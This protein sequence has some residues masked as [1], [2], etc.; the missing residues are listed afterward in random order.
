MK[1]S[2]LRLVGFKTFVDPTEIP[3]EPGLSGIVGPNG[4]GKSNLV[5]ALRWVM[6]E[7][8]YKSLRA[9]EMDDVIF[10]GSGRRP[11]RNT[12]EVSLRIDNR[13]RRA[14]VSFNDDEEL[15][16]TRRIEREAGSAYRINGRDVRARD[17]QLLFADAATGAHSA[18][19]VRQGQI[20]ELIAA[21][22]QA[23]R[24]VLEDA[25]GIGGLYS[26][27]HEAELR[28]KAAE[29]NLERLDDLITEVGQT[30]DQLRRQAKQARRYRDLSEEIRRLEAL[31][32]QLRWTRANAEI[33]AAT[34]ALDANRHSV[35]TATEAA[36]K[37]A[38][39]RTEAQ[40][41]LPA[42][43]EAEAAAGARLRRLV[44]ERDKLSDK[45][46]G[47]GARRAEIERRLE[48]IA[49]DREREDAQVATTSET[50]ER[51]DADIAVLRQQMADAEQS[52]EELVAA[53][54]AAEAELRD[55]EGG[56]ADAT[57]QAAEL[58]ARRN[59]LE[60][61]V[62]E[63]ATRLTKLQAQRAEV[64]Q[65]VARI[66]A[67]FAGSEETERLTASREAAQARVD[68]C[69]QAIREAETARQD[70]SAAEAEARAP[71]RDAENALNSLE[72]EQ[73]TLV[74]LLEAGG[75]D[76]FP[77]VVGDV[78]VANGFETAL[79]AA[80][81]DDLER[82][83]DERAGVHWRLMSGG[84]DPALPDGVRPLSA[85]VEAPEV[86][87][88]RLAQI[89][90][91]PR[92]EGARL[93]S[94]LQAGQI[95]VS[96]EG[97]V[98]RWDG[99]VSS[100]EAPTPAATRLAQ[101]NRVAELD[102]EIE[103]ARVQLGTASATLET[104]ASR[105]MA[106]QTREAETRAALREAQ[107]ELSTAQDA[108]TAAERQSGQYTAR[109]SALEEAR[110]RLGQ[111]AEESAA[112]EADA[113]Q[114]LDGLGSHDAMVKSVEDLRQTVARKR[115]AF[116]E[117]RATADGQ[118]REREM[119]AR[120]LD[121]M[122]AEVERWRARA[123][124]TKEHLGTLAKREAELTEE[125]KVL[126][127]EPAR[128]TAERDKVA[129]RISEAETDRAKA[130]DAHAVGETRQAEADRAARAADQL[131]AER[132]EHL[133]R[134]EATLE[135]LTAR[136]GEIAHA[137]ED[138]L[139]CAPDALSEI[140]GQDEID[141]MVSAEATES[142]LDRLKVDRDRMGA[143]NLRAET[144]AA[145]AEA[146]FEELTKDR[147]DLDQA[148]RKLRHGIS[149]LNSEGR[150]RL[151]SA[152][153]EVNEHFKTL[154]STLFGG[155]TAELKLT[156]SDDPLEAGLEIIARP[157]GKRPQTLTLLSGGEQALT[158]IAL[159]FAVF[160]TNPS[161]ICVL[162]EVDAPLDDANVERFC[163][164]MDEMA[165]ITDTR[166]LIITHNPITMSRVDRLFGVT[167]AEKGVSQMVSVDLVAANGLR[168]AE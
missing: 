34:E 21:K 145:E 156:E 27:R 110:I 78:R 56:L 144:E 114:A 160:L 77:P 137:I 113:A 157:P 24:K 39:E 153:T 80:L 122:S 148:I 105:S 135:G 81:G 166:Y 128:L 6:G 79:G 159:I 16:V 60:R 70:A 4:C 100:A 149:S 49:R 117:K 152:F 94:A 146:R 139:G 64:D 84:N 61:Q 10:A 124:E 119:H 73:R 7:N 50:V 23:R 142:R 53:A 74:G 126:T 67:E 57:R 62:K 134:A 121:Q 69:E 118:Q 136:R 101:R 5:E 95:L 86:L 163:N 123:A 143:V 8:S 66:T 35:E 72:A 93:Q 147:D 115:A 98:W 99:I 91:V 14:P 92:S 19:M 127:R 22:P 158:A 165:R 83:T 31:I 59:Q 90:I 41:A 125:R 112:A 42:L 46:E 140:S 107:K 18:A 111:S 17:V 44:Q 30:R 9:S 48:E 138:H 13:S 129:E 11:A 89:G 167:M 133:A 55:A 36:A 108:L 85:V 54:S 25:A 47:V 20:G 68:A 43:R 161:P 15:E 131:L 2:R 150:Q 32:H 51:L 162:D 168:A 28:L 76:Q 37:A 130:A 75:D 154:F 164:L 116:A 88:R 52:R 155:G 151:L 109:L 1:F 104:A 26:R 45:L 87:N 71:V 40:A 132:R 120:Q 103:T 106:A 65:E 58:T 29:A 96:P 33:T 102:G 141:D 3:I 38:T 12:A 97:D 63:H 82:P